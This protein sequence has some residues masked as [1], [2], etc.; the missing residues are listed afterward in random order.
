M[1]THE[2]GIQYYPRKSGKLKISNVR[3]TMSLE[4]NPSGI[5]QPKVTIETLEQGLKYDQ[6]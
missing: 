4:L 5:Y 3:G 1:I 6:S 2:K